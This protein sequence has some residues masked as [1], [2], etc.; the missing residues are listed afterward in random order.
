[1]NRPAI[2]LNV[3]PRGSRLLD[4]LVEAGHLTEPLLQDLNARLMVLPIVDGRVELDD[5]RRVAAQVLF[6]HMDTLPKPV[7]RTLRQEWT[8]MF[9]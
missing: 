3:M 5:V 7:Q 4:I 9:S 1:M 6:E 2:I 8:T